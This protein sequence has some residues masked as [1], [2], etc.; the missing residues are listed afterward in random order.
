MF[1]PDSLYRQILPVMPIPCVDLLVVDR[2]RNILLLKRRNEPAKGLWWVPGGRVHMGETRAASAARKL[3]EECGLDLQHN[4]PKEIST[5]DLFLPIGQG[6][7]SHTIC[8]VFL[9]EVG[10]GAPVVLDSQSDASAWRTAQDWRTEDLH[11]YVRK[12]VSYGLA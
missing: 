12:I 8:T 4:P 11:P 9:V 10:A 2:L 6:A 5:E 7:I 1:I 3:R